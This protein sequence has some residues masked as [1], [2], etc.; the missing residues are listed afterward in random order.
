M[1]VVYHN[2]GVLKDLPCI[3]FISMPLIHSPQHL[4]QHLAKKGDP[5]AFYSL[6]APYAHATYQAIRT[7]GKNH[8]EAMVQLVPFLKKLYRGF[9]RKPDDEDFDSWYTRN[10]KKQFGKELE[11]VQESPDEIYLE[12]ISATDLSHLDSQMKLLFMRNYS[13]ARKERKGL[14]GK[15]RF[16][17]SSRT[18]WWIAALLFFGGAAVAFHVYLT[19]SNVRIS[20]NIASPSFNRSITF[21]S[22][23]NKR[24]F[25]DIPPSFPS[26]APLDATVPDSGAAA[27]RI[28]DSVHNALITVK[29]TF[30]ARPV[31]HQTV[32]PV[33][34][35][36]A[37]GLQ[38][39]QK[40]SSRFSDSLAPVPQKV[41]RP[42]P[43]TSL[44][45]P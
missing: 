32:T 29:K 41:R 39:Q 6:V 7:S 4:L 16:L 28:S 3:Y 5:S 44:I 17:P 35:Q 11:P 27:Q 42:L 1:Q 14:S 37:P 33:P 25:P 26:R 10:R 20:L 24:I 18:F 12:R 43:D 34:N 22:V 15:I 38:G 36:A 2:F 21:P 23:I 8:K 40:S 45:S 31:V 13:R 19:F 30:P 9:P